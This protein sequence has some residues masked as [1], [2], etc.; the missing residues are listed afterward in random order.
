MALI[1]ESCERGRCQND[2]ENQL[3]SPA[4]CELSPELSD[5]GLRVIHAD[6]WRSA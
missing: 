2:S 3:A 1:Q 4:L 6:S 5:L